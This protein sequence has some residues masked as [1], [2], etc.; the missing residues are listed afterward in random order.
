MFYM[1]SLLR[2]REERY[3]QRRGRDKC[4]IFW[5]SANM[6][7]ITAAKKKKKAHTE[8]IITLVMHTERPLC[9]SPNGIHLFLVP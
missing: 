4:I 2:E 1:N 3:K 5:G 9:S 8:I 7:L 6:D